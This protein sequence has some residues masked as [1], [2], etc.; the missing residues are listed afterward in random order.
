MLLAVTMRG[1]FRVKCP[2]STPESQG[3]SP[4]SL[5]AVM[6]PGAVEWTL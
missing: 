6:K 5:S 2:L 4:L 1:E 3:Y